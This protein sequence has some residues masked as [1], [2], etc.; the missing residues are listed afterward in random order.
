MNEG[1]DNTLM[2]PEEE[3]C[4]VCA[5]VTD[6]GAKQYWRYS[7]AQAAMQALISE[8]SFVYETP[9]APDKVLIPQYE[10]V[11]QYAVKQA[12]SLL[13]ELEKEK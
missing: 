10:R 3:C 11:A 5:R 2:I 1:T 8:M 12:D 7:F 13:A 4:P 6:K 9:D